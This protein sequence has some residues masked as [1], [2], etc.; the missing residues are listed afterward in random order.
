MPCTCDCDTINGSGTSTM[1]QAQEFLKK[2][3]ENNDLAEQLQL[4]YVLATVRFASKNGYSFTP[5]EYLEATSQSAEQTLDVDQLESVSGG[6]FSPH[7]VSTMAVGEEGG[8]RLPN[9]NSTDW[10]KLNF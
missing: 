9:P 10:S 1:S 4:C 5:D 3:D 6:V 2:L 8:G 7:Y